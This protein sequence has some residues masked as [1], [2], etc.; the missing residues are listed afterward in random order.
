[1][2]RAFSRFLNP[3]WYLPV[4]LDTTSL[5]PLDY[6][7]HVSGGWNR[8]SMVYFPR[9]GPKG[10]PWWVIYIYNFVH[11]NFSSPPKFGRGGEGGGVVSYFLKRFI[12]LIIF[13]HIQEEDKVST[14]G[15]LPHGW[16]DGPTLVLRISWSWM[17]EW[18]C[19]GWK[20]KEG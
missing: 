7:I 16:R 10:P 19:S 4:G 9:V 6:L 20:E 8:V 1:M 18:Y 14:A 3:E 15:Y 5:V 13:D 12:Y 11:F 17:G 2:C